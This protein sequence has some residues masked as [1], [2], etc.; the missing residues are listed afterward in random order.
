MTDIII[1]NG[2]SS[3]GKTTI[4]KC[5][6]NTSTASWLRFSIDDL[7]EA[8]PDAMLKKDSGIKLDEDGSV[9]PGTEFRALESAWRH[10]LG[11]MARRGARIIIDDVFLSGIEARKRWEIS[12]DGLQV[13]WVGVMCDP[14]V[15]AV[16]ERER[17][18]RIEGMA[19]SQAAAVHEGMQYDISVDTSKTSPEECARMIERK[20]KV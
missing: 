15:A 14:T 17:E 2:G 9:R 7:I 10:G 6:Q 20:I 18:D 5:L 12:L 8:M 1:L 3:S 13:L 4:A 11:E 16:R 19:V